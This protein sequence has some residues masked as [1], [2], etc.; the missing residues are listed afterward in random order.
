MS[1]PTTVPAMLEAPEMAVARAFSLGWTMTDLYEQGMPAQMHPP[2]PRERLP[3]AGKLS[4]SQRALLRLDQI[5]AALSSLSGAIESHG[6]RVPETGGLRDAQRYEETE[7]GKRAAIYALH[8]ELLRA[9]TAADVRLGKA[10]GL[11][12]A[13]A[14]TCRDSQSRAELEES[15]G[16]YRLDN[17]RGW[18]NDS[19]STLP[20]HGAK[21]VLTGLA[22]W[23]AWVA[24]LGAGSEPDTEWQE[25][26]GEIH[27][28]LHRQGEMWRSVLAGEKDAGDTLNT[29]SYL[30]AADTMTQRAFALAWRFMS[31]SALG[32]ALLL[33]GLV[34]VV[35]LAWGLASGGASQLTTGI[36][37]AAAALGIT[38]KTVGTAM[39]KLG[40]AL[41]KPMWEAELDNAVG[42]AL[43]FLPLAPVREPGPHVLLDAPRVL[44]ETYVPTRSAA[45]ARPRQSISESERRYLLSWAR[46]A[47]YVEPATDGAGAGG[48]RLSDVGRHLADIPPSECGNVCAILGAGRGL[49]SHASVNGREAHA[50]ATPAPENVR[51]ALAPATTTPVEEVYDHE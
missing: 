12:R 37:A 34:A 35:L 30:K 2:K 47:G 24:N 4:P 20:R 38:W 28:T 44:R 43:T 10:Y 8:L 13:L 26:A 7:A 9:L 46:A 21:A 18:L 27:T 14:D 41:E 1:S 45:G 22:R 23:E 17:L 11:G 3:G 29:D 16:R 33:L 36:A 19:A 15:F 5:D 48:E 49:G 31:R 42:E 50:D 40:E 51:P 25:A 32:V 6:L 39:Q